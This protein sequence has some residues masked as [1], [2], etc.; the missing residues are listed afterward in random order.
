MAQIN[1]TIVFGAKGYESQVVVDDCRFMNEV[2]AFKAAG[3]KLIRIHIEDDLQIKRLK[4]TYGKKA[5]QHIS[6]RK[7]DS[8][9][10]MGDMNDK[11]F[12]L[13]VN[14]V[15]DDSVVEQVLA[16]VMD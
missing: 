7:D 3:Y 6:N 10:E 16:W 4:Q 13:V 2:R 9:S 12:D 15:D 11:M 14:A 5:D 1:Q 8:E